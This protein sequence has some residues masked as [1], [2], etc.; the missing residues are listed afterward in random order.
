MIKDLLSSLRM[1]GALEA[2]DH[3]SDLKERDQYLIALLKAEL[4]HRELNANKR[5][6]SQAKFPIEKEW[7]D[8]DRALNPS[9]DFSKIES[10]VCLDTI[11]Q[12]KVQDVFMSIKFLLNSSQYRTKKPG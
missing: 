1:S 4:D 6:L 5:R 11:F 9:I 12:V 3:L 7:R 10:Q 8:L 2:L